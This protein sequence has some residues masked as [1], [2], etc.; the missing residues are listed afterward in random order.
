[1]TP[2]RY[3]E[4]KW[5]DVPS[6]I[7]KATLAMA[8]TKRGIYLEGGVGCGKTHICWAIKN[9]LDTTSKTR[10]VEFWNVSTLLQEI[11]NDYDRDGYSKVRPAENIINARRTLLILD[12]IGAEKATEFAAEMLYRIINHRYNEMIPTIFTSNLSL[13]ALAEQIGERSA[14]RIAE[15]CD[16]IKINGEDRRV[17]S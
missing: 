1:M 5:S 7:Q 14:S 3:K 8:Q 10:K 9:F 4:A 12:D 11:R 16:I 15:M 13:G 17:Q 2:E 6:D